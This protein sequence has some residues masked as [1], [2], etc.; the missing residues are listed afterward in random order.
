MNNF[1]LKSFYEP[2]IPIKLQPHLYKVAKSSIDI[3]DGILQDLSHL[4]SF[5][6]LGAIIDL[7][8]VPLSAQCKILINN[9]KINIRDIFSQGDDYQFLF[10][11]G[12]ENR[13]KIKKLS[14]RLNIKITKI[15]KINKD[16]LICFKYK[17]EIFDASS[18]KKGYTHSF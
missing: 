17:N 1:F 14:K 11:S 2:N 18:L 7:K 10:T 15:G 5:R 6:K 12:L 8:S 16:K 3:S 9:N 4:C 13:S